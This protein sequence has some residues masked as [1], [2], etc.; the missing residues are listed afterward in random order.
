MTAPRAGGNVNRTS[1][2]QNRG[3]PSKVVEDEDE[4]ADMDVG[5]LL[6]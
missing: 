4:F 2:Q 5:R 3:K 1:N 6:E